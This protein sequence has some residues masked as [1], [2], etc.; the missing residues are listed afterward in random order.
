M[1]RTYTEL[2]KLP[3]FKERY[4]Y[5]KLGSRI[6]EETFGFDRYLNQKFY[7]LPE[8]KRVRDQ[9]II[10]DN[11]CDLAMEDYEIYGRIIIHHMNPINIQDI[12]KHSELILDPEQLICTSI[13]THNAIH[14]GEEALRSKEPVVRK[15][16]DTCLW[17]KA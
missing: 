6:G 12:I 9:V 3:T 8:W 4:E 5:L 16:N 11:G 7:K 17:R 1:I 10:R 15:P 14:Y 2:I 13:S